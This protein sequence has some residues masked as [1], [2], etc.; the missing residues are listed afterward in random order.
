MSYRCDIYLN[1]ECDN[2]SE[3]GYTHINITD[4]LISFIYLKKK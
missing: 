4:T 1:V 3:N 2:Y